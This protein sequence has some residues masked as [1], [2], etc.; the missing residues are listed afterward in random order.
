M[1]IFTFVAM[2]ALVLSAPLAAAPADTTVR[3]IHPAAFNPAADADK[4]IHLAIAEAGSSH[5]K[6][7][8]DVGGNWCKWCKML[9]A[10]F[11]STPDVS[12]LLHDKYVVVKVNFSKENE[13]KAV[14][15]RYP[16]VAGYPHFFVLNSDGT[17][18]CSKN[19]GELEKGQGY[20]A[21][22]MKAFLTQWAK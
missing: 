17:L 16:K 1:K 14:L 13:N 15:S 2:L 11:E 12:R 4:E 7:L 6:I 19:T 20:D 8:L 18:L 22:K 21:V 3:A 5:K 10:F 9:D